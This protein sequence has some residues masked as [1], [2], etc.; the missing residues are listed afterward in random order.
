[1]ALALLL[2][3]GATALALATGGSVAG[4]AKLRFR[5]SRLV[6]FAVVAQLLGEALARATNLSGFYAAGLAISALAAL[7]F[8]ARNRRIAGVPLVAVGLLLNAVVVSANGSMPVSAAAAARAGV[9]TGEIVA[10][11]D[12]RH[13]MAGPGTTWRRLADV[14]PV[15]LP[16]H[17]E[18]SSPGD[19]F[20]AAGLGELVFLGMRPPRRR[21]TTKRRTPTAVALR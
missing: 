20:V 12:A 17:P 3:V 15:P 16:L 19:L 10:G 4:L 6:V 9:A 21:A 8:C 11:D 13:S 14:I 1:M 5:G 18:V 7:A 2:V